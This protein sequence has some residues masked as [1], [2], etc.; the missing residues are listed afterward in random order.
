MVTE[1]TRNVNRSSGG[2]RLRWDDRGAMVSDGVRFYCI[3]NRKSLTYIFFNVYLFIV[4]GNG[5]ERE[6]EREKERENTNQAPCLN[7]MQSSIPRIMRSQPEQNLRV[8][9]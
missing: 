8:E 2:R 1:F 6:R 3:A 5:R 7:P 4:R 9:R